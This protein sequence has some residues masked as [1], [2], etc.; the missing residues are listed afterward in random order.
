MD[1]RLKPHTAP[2]SPHGPHSPPTAP[3]APTAPTAPTAPGARRQGIRGPGWVTGSRPE[4]HGVG[5]L[6]FCPWAPVSPWSASVDVPS[7][8]RPLPT[9]MTLVVDGLTDG[10]EPPSTCVLRPQKHKQGRAGAGGAPSGP[11]QGRADQMLRRQRGAKP[12]DRLPQPRRELCPPCGSTHRAPLLATWPILL[13]A[14][15]SP[16]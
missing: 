12:A 7:A 8:L 10:A 13:S 11:K 6:R 1:W 2:H 14:E 9:I 16:S 4:A 3:M 5:R 15:R